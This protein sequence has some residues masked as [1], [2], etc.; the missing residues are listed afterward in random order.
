MTNKTFNSSISKSEI[1]LEKVAQETISDIAFAAN[2]SSILAATSW[3]GTFKVWH[4]DEKLSNCSQIYE[5]KDPKRQKSSLLRVTFRND[6]DVAYVSNIHG[7]IYK[8]NPEEKCEVIG[9]H[10]GPVFGLKYLP[11]KNVIVSASSD[12]NL[13]MWDDRVK[14]LIAKMELP[15][16]AIYAD[17]NHD[18]VVLALN[19]DKVGI[20]NL[21][22]FPKIT[23]EEMNADCKSQL[24]SI[25]ISSDGSSFIAGSFTGALAFGD[26]KT[27][28][29]TERKQIHQKNTSPTIGSNRVAMTMEKKCALSAGSDGRVAFINMET[30]KVNEKEII[31]GATHISAIAASSKYPLYA[32]ASGYDW[33]RGGQY[34]LENGM[35]QVEMVLCKVNSTDF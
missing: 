13:C 16:K 21:T 5:W 9:Q 8:I 23:C 24:T 17:A 3:D 2:S 20:V 22:A 29:I 33:S 7:E 35:G 25:A 27:K 6:K 18:S 28:K 26:I 19:G 12:R 15:S 14:G 1:K 34:A 32:L 30:G 4:F 31:K 11:S 10:L